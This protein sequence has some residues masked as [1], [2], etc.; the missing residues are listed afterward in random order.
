MVYQISSTISDSVGYTLVWDVVQATP[1]CEL[2][3]GTI[4]TPTN[5]NIINSTPYISTVEVEI[6]SLCTN[7]I[8]RIRI[9]NAENSLC[10]EKFV[11]LNNEEE[12]YFHYECNAIE[13]GCEV[14]LG[15][16]NP[17]NPD[18]YQTQLECS[19]CNNCPCKINSPNCDS[20]LLSAYYQCIPNI[21][22]A[23]IIN[24]CLQANQTTQPV[25]LT[26]VY[27]G[28]PYNSVIYD[29]NNG[30]APLTL[31]TIGDCVQIIVPNQNLNPNYY[32]LT[33]YIG[34]VTC[35]MT[36]NQIVMFPCNGVNFPPVSDGGC[37][38]S[39]ETTDIQSNVPGVI[40]AKV[41]D[42]SDLN[43]DYSQ[44]LYL[45][46]NNL[47]V[48]DKFEV[49]NGVPDYISL[50]SPLTPALQSMLIASTPYVGALPDTINEPGCFVPARAGDDLYPVVEGFWQGSNALGPYHP[51]ANPGMTSGNPFISA[52]VPFPSLSPPFSATQ[53]N[54]ISYIGDGWASGRLTI[55]GGTYSNPITIVGHGNNAQGGYTIPGS[56]PKQ[57]N[58][59]LT[60]WKYNLICP[61]CDDVCILD[62]VNLNYNCTSGAI[63]FDFDSVETSL[64]SYPILVNILPLSGQQFTST[65]SL[66]SSGY[67]KVTITAP[68]TPATYYYPI[69]VNYNSTGLD[70]MITNNLGGDIRYASVEIFFTQNN[71]SDIHIKSPSGVWKITAN[72]L[73]GCYTEKEITEYCNTCDAELTTSVNDVC[74]DTPVNITVT[75]TGFPC[76]IYNN[77]TITGTVPSWLTVSGNGNNEVIISGSAAS[78]TSDV[79]VSF[80]I[81]VQCGDCQ[82]SIPIEFTAF[83]PN[84]NWSSVIT[85]EACLNGDG[86]ISINATSCNAPLPINW[87]ASGGGGHSGTI[88]SF[89]TNIL[90]D[91]IRAG[92]Y[93]IDFEDANGCKWEN[94]YNVP[95]IGGPS[96]A[97]ISDIVLDCCTLNAGS[98]DIVI[99]GG[100]ANYDINIQHYGGA[101]VLANQVGPTVTID[102]SDIAPSGLIEGTYYVTVEDS[103][104]CVGTTQF[105]ISR[106]PNPNF[107]LYPTFT[108]C[109]ASN[110]GILVSNMTNIGANSTIYYGQGITCNALGSQIASSSTITGLAA[111]TYTV[112]VKNNVTCCCTCKTTTIAN[113][114]T[115]LLPPA[116]ATYSVCPNNS[117]TM[118]ASCA[119]GSTRWILNGNVVHVGST[120]TV[121]PTEAV[122]YQVQCFDPIVLC[123]SSSV[124]HSI[125]MLEG[126][127]VSTLFT[128]PCK[129]QSSPGA[130]LPLSL[131]GCT[132]TVT[133]YF[134]NTP[135]TSETTFSWGTATPQ[136]GLGLW[137]T[138]VSSNVNLTYQC[139]NSAGCVS[140][141]QAIVIPKN[142]PEVQ[143]QSIQSCI[144]EQV[145]LSSAVTSID[146]LPYIPVGYTATFYNGWGCTGSVVS[147][148]FTPTATIK[149]FSVKITSPE[150]CSTCKNFSVLGV[151]NPTVTLT[152]NNPCAGGTLLLSSTPV[153]SGATY[154]WT[155]NGSPIAGTAPSI[156]INNVNT[157]HNGVYQVTVTKGG[158]TGT[159]SV[160]VSIQPQQTINITNASFCKNSGVHYLS[161]GGS[162]SGTYTYT[163]VSGPSNIML[164]GSP[165]N[166]LGINTAGAPVDTYVYQVCTT[167]TCNSCTNVTITITD[168][169]GME[170][171]IKCKT[172]SWAEIINNYNPA[173]QYYWSHSP[174]DCNSGSW[175][176]ITNIFALAWTAPI[177]YFK[178]VDPVTGCCKSASTPFIL[179][180]P[181]MS[182]NNTNCTGNGIGQLLVDIATISLP[183]N[184]SIIINGVNL[185]NG[186]TFSLAPI[187]IPANTSNQL[188]EIISNL[189]GGTWQLILY[190]VINNIPFTECYSGLEIPLLCCPSCQNPFQSYKLANRVISL[191]ERPGF[192]PAV[193]LEVKIP[194]IFS[195][196]GALVNKIDPTSEMK[197]F[198]YQG[199]TLVHETSWINLFSSFPT[200]N[201]IPI[202]GILSPSTSYTYILQV[203]DTGGIYSSIHGQITT[204][205]F[206]DSTVPIYAWPATAEQPGSDANLD[207][208]YITYDITMCDTENSIE[209]RVDGYWTLTNNL[210]G[211]SVSV[212]DSTSGNAEIPFNIAITPNLSLRLELGNNGGSCPASV[213][214]NPILTE[215]NKMLFDLFFYCGS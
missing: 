150:G 181:E 44:D 25:E 194:P 49:F 166:S 83:K 198:I 201:T 207:D 144:G 105:T 3:V 33:A 50:Y 6:N 171:N 115:S 12:E 7:A 24:V 98:V 162:N 8:F 175:T 173:Y 129:S 210:T 128:Q 31:S 136:A 51:T 30:D 202:N 208:T 23:G 192:G 76:S 121:T 74:Y 45:D 19:N 4:L 203:R 94:V 78:I 134:A 142:L 168:I 206:T 193:P 170:L 165:T 214:T 151:S 38:V 123:A 35:P 17:L 197:L 55:K 15:A 213:G 81:N 172:A 111:G 40:F 120:Y 209:T 124:N 149:T 135:I 18:H 167:G 48:A 92:M 159:A 97:P 186:D 195:G 145:N 53:V 20:V 80:T 157:S 130:L 1:D 180:V 156:T 69:N 138:N 112:C 140:T 188:L 90:I 57:C 47:T 133:W 183:F 191:K 116:P 72:S 147:N 212:C 39:V 110:G 79:N 158:C 70:F 86:S 107:V 178:V 71:G 96:I 215:D 77:H 64:P 54:G 93:T 99:S 67:A 10:E 34:T 100:T 21:A 211:D 28:S 176:L 169:P 196:S 61:N 60:V 182:I 65:Y 163:Y 101:T 85:P 184:Y 174:G 84:C 87:T 119:S 141:A 9:F 104:G 75:G 114:G 62:I 125:S 11:T 152:A 66:L 160:T 205:S 143:T 148:L 204:D 32:Y 153:I 109:E 108:Y 95:T 187:A 179:N 127:N 16:Y 126:D 63:S 139:L 37:C 59:S 26:Q 13:Q 117:V 22:G 132:G 43:G 5:S 122:T 146:G 88:N 164:G 131:T 103:N 42:L 56:P 154:S 190:I 199:T 14:K 137:L 27:I 36:A 118:S 29:I 189:S 91:N 113:I 2:T 41:V 82:D 106:L 73:N 161:V 68:G 58:K 200:L 89:P 102:T 46:F 155:K 177:I 185:T 52:P